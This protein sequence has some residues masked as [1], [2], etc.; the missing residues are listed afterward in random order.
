M[1]CVETFHRNVHTRAAYQASEFEGCYIDGD[2]FALFGSPS[3]TDYNNAVG[4]SGVT[5]YGRSS[6]PC[7]GEEGGTE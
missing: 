6:L 1:L 5:T 4:G 3:C 7:K 2:I